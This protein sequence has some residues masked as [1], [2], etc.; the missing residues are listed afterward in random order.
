MAKTFSTA[1]KE[2][3]NMF[4]TGTSFK[5]DGKD[6]VVDLSGKPTCSKGEPKTDIYIKAKSSCND[7]KEFKISFKKENAEFLEN[8]TNAE[9]AEQLFGEFWSSII[10]NATSNLRNDF[11][12]RT[13]IYKKKIGKTDAGAITLGWKFELLTVP[14]GHLSGNMQLTREQVIDVYAGTNLTGDK[15]DSSVNGMTISNSGVANFILVQNQPIQNAQQAINSLISIEDY[16]NQNPDVYFACK[17]LN[18][19][20]FKHKYDGNRPLAVYV[21]WSVNNGKLSHQICFD[22]PLQ[23][24]GNY[25]Y[26][27]LKKALD[28]LGIETTDDLN[29]ENVEYPDNMYE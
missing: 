14:S 13:L 27:R 12:S 23:Q 26:E 21:D 5:Y 9:R 3:L 6:Y 15:R 25:A 2:I 22:T 10:S 20:S 7:Y 24:G 11:L 4:T 1:E 17:A 16:V 18:Y 8:K 19:R 29:E 28:Q